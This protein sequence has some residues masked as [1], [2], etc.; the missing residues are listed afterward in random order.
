MQASSRVFAR[1]FSLINEISSPQS[2]SY[3]YLDGFATNEQYDSS[4]LFNRRSR[5]KPCSVVARCK[6]IFH[7]AWSARKSW[8][9]NSAE[10][11][12]SRHMRSVVLLDAS[13]FLVCRVD[14]MLLLCLFFMLSSC[15]LV[16]SSVIF[17]HCYL[18]TCR[19]RQFLVI[20]ISLIR[21]ISGMEQMKSEFVVWRSARTVRRL[22]NVTFFALFSLSFSVVWVRTWR[23]L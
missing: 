11:T 10:N 20:L 22:Q 15:S 14:R 8:P 9:A 13:N 3:Y 6:E 17:Q 7:A 19:C 1:L 23:R 5:F 16:L 4:T 21:L 18:D 2:I 12:I